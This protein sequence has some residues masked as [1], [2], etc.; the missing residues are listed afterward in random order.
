MDYKE[1]KMVWS[2]CEECELCN[3]RNK[4][5][6]ARGRLPCDVLFV[7]EAPGASEDILGKPFVGPAGKLLDQIILRARDIVEYDFSFCITNLVACI[8]KDASNKKTGEPSEESIK[9][10]RPR[11]VEMIEMAQ[12]NI[13]V[14][15]GKL[16]TKW[17]K[18]QDTTGIVIV[19]IIHPA[20]IL[21]SDISQRGLLL[22]RAVV[23]VSDV[24]SDE[25]LVE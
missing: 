4:V 25:F 17:I 10:C 20:S 7:G 13:I 18:L 11:L 23:I 3:Y 1:H 6:L 16:S 12:P 22:Q 15:V 24:V 14:C 2:N 5:V 9:S 21:R 19:D 8:P